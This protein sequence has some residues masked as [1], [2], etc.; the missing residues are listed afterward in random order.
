MNITTLARQLRLAAVT[1]VFEQGLLDEKAARELLARPLSPG[2]GSMIYD[3][4]ALLSDPDGLKK[5]AGSV[6][7]PV[8]A[9]ARAMKG[10]TMAWDCQEKLKSDISLLVDALF[11]ALHLTGLTAQAD[12]AGRLHKN[13]KLL[14]I[15][16]KA[17]DRY[18]RIRSEFQEKIEA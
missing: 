15:T 4:S 12:K 8:A 11:L 3:D 14:R 17:W 9:G 18:S 10:E 1:N 7:E 16:K 13:H 6:P 2:D 5:I